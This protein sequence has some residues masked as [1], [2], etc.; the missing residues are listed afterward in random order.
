[1][2]SPCPRETIATGSLLNISLATRRYE[3]WLA[4][5]TALYRP[6]LKLKHDLMREG[7]FPF[8]R[9]TFYRWVQVWSE[10]CSELVSAPEVLAIGDLHVENFGTWRDRE[11][12][13]IWGVNDF[14]EAYPLPYTND[15][16]RLAASAEIAD[17]TDDLQIKPKEACEAILTGYTKAMKSAGEPLVLEEEHGQLRAMALGNLRAPARFWQ[18]LE[19]QKKLEGSVPADARKTLEDLMPEPGLPYRLLSRVSGLGS[20]GRYRV[21]AIGDWCGGKVAREAKALALSA[22]VWARCG[23]ASDTLLYQS[24]LDRAVRCRDPF[25]LV[26]GSWV[27]RRLSPHCSRIPIDDLPQERDEHRLLYFMGWETAN[28]HLGSK[29]AVDA[30]RRDLTKRPAGWLHIAANAMVK[31]VTRD[32]KD[33]KSA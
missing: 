20:L 1:M 33:W 18:K 24:I 16:V 7:V 3:E 13:L 8:F 9:A 28:V 32:W 22:C 27:G 10:I 29:K 23:T 15:L 4:K 6:H 19:A 26:N 17:A 12:R 30:I 5:Y 31:S 21:V 2:K 25:V 11:G 14:D